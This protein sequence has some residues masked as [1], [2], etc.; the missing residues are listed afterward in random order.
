MHHRFTKYREFIEI[1]ATIVVAEILIY[2]LLPLIDPS[3]SGSES[4]ILHASVLAILAGP[5]VLRIAYTLFLQ[6][7]TVARSRSSSL[8]E[9][10]RRS[11]IVD[12]LV[13]AACVTIGMFCLITVASTSHSRVEDALAAFKAQEHN[14]SLVVQERVQNVFLETYQQ[15]RTVARLPGVKKIDRYAANF[16]ADAKTA[17]QEIYNNLA[18]VAPISEFYI[19]PADLNPDTL[20]P[21]TGENQ[22]PIVTFDQ[23]IV[24]KVGGDGA[25]VTES[26]HEE[27]EPE[28]EESEIYEYR[29]MKEQL[30]YFKKNFPREIDFAGLEYPAICGPQV[31]TCD[32]SHFDPKHPDDLDRSG[33]VYSVPFYGPDGLLKGC[34]SAVALTTRI[35]EELVVDPDRALVHT[36][37]SYSAAGK[38]TA[39]PVGMASKLKSELLLGKPDSSLLYSEV[40]PLNIRDRGGQWIVW[41]AADDA[42]F[43]DAASTQILERDENLGFVV[44]ALITLLLSAS[45]WSMRGAKS[46]AESLAR[47]MTVDLEIAKTAAESATR[48]KSAFL[49]NMSHEI[50]TPLTA[51][52]GFADLLRE[53]DEVTLSPEQRIQTVETIRSAGT[54]LL[55]VINDILDLSKI[56]ADKMTLEKIET[57]FVAVLHEVQSLMRPRALEKGLELQVTLATP[58]P[59]YIMGD[60]TR[61]RQ[62]LMN[63]VGNAVKFSN[64]GIV[65]VIAHVD[66]YPAGQRL[67]IDIEDTGPGMTPEQAGR[68]FQAFSQADDSVTR[69]FGG[70]GLGLTICRRLVALMDGSVT[71][72]RTAPGLGSTFCINLSLLPVPGTRM[73][74]ELQAV[75]SATPISNTTST[76]LKGRILFAED[77]PDNQRLIAFHLRRAGAIVEIADNGLIALELLEKHAAAGTPFDL[78]LT[79]MQMP[80]MD[81]YTL[82][83]TLRQRGSTLPIIALTAHAMAED[84][85]KCKVAGCSDYATKPIDKEALLATCAHWLINPGNNHKQAA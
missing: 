75:K 18:Q 49:A 53:G 50:R 31:I 32:N 25:S 44:A 56:E 37:T 74:T 66:E 1:I 63:L 4:I 12:A 19:V 40:L 77:G 29:L 11:L 6:R 28:L 3:A 46:R 7:K 20:D 82:A 22:T 78:L 24:G 68:L 69:K 83:R 72:T 73:I 65:K 15:I 5:L 52:M 14:K 54:H 79:D 84:Y 8:Q 55:T 16:D 57:S 23:L 67:L 47:E 43:L 10:Q 51:I 21:N 64:T 70:T 13:V 59:E 58:V 30:A 33:L 76:K 80:E 35:Q 38:S 42:S 41:S 61:L 48:A 60:P 81:G 27:K 9:V 85:A 34:I 62:V 71:L 17:V 45:A 36:S 26:A 2:F 39:L